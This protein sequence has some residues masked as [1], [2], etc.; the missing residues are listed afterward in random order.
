MASKVFHIQSGTHQSLNLTQDLLRSGNYGH[1]C[2]RCRQEQA[3]KLLLYV[4][5]HT[6][7]AGVVGL[8]EDLLD[9]AVLD[10]Q[11]IPLAPLVS[12]DRRAVEGKVER[13]GE[14]ARGVTQE[15]DLVLPVRRF[16]FPYHLTV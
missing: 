8:D 2:Q 4:M 11:G 15:P 1:S 12:E 5:R 6:V 13:L 7:D 9:L 16:L 14:L 3:V 10:P